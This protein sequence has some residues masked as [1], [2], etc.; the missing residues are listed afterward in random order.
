M[1]VKYK[2]DLVK[3]AAVAFVDRR[4][5]IPPRLLSPRDRLRRVKFCSE[6]FGQ[7]WLGSVAIWFLD[8][9]IDERVGPERICGIMRVS[10]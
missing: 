5:L 9:S 3:F 1:A 2:L 8:S 6:V 4:L 7:L 10:S